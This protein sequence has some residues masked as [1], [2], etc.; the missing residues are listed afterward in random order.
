MIVV[1]GLLVAFVLIIL[2]SNPNTRKC[3]WRED[4]SGDRDGARCYKCRACGA[5]DFTTNGKPPLVCRVNPER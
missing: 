2:F 3:R 1:I 5:K 4:R